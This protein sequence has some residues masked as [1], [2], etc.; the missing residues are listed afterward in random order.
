MADINLTSLP[1]SGHSGEAVPN[2]FFRQTGAVQDLAILFPGL[3]Y[4][5]DMPL[6][7]YPARLLVER[8]ADVL[9]L[10]VDY[11]RPEFQSRER[12]EQVL[13]MGEDAR[14]AAQAGMGQRNYD[15]LVLIGKSIGTFSLAYLV[16]QGGYSAATTIWLTPLL[17]Q[18][19]LVQAASQCR[20][21]ALFVAGTGDTTYD[22][23][24]LVRIREATG[25]R[26]LILDGGNHSLEVPGE[27]DRSIAWIGKYVQE[28]KS[29]LSF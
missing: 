25:A 26:A 16:T 7:Y 19:W 29:F 8:G 2:R 3:N 27:L 22:P 11:T 21:P 13:W 15:R 14:A 9:Q 23:A 6:L 5:C 18:P 1:I 10:R 20:G 4:T 12:P 17:R 28:I 24:A